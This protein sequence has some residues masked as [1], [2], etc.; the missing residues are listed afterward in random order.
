MDNLTNK[1]Y[2]FL[3]E[4]YKEKDINKILEE[5]YNFYNNNNLEEDLQKK[6]DIRKNHYFV[7][8]TYSLLNNFQKQQYY[9]LPVIDN[10]LSHNRITDK[11][12]IDI[13][14]IHKILPSISNIID[15]NL[16]INILKKLTNDNYKFSRIN[17]H[18]CNNVINTNNYHFDD[19]S[20]KFT[21]YLND[22]EE[23]YG[24]G[25][26]F[27]E[28]THKNKKFSNNNI[29]NFYGKKGD[30]LISYQNGF[31]RKLPQK[32]SINYFLV[33]NFEKN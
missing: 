30:V 14:N 8:N 4:I 23:I 2:V 22:V 10:R 3:K 15:I 17:L 28:G 31:H 12:M 13:F 11:G 24:G 27:I 25:L 19:N 29:K 21:I 6:E 26:S 1:G 33:I 18:I 7:N 16:I 9:Y 32:N 20:I 5:F